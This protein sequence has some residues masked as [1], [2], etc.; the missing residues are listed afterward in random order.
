MVR[1]ET[2]WITA[3]SLFW[4]LLKRVRLSVCGIAVAAGAPNVSFPKISVPKTIW[5]LEFSEHLL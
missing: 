5:D 4:F 3:L 1:D 2:P